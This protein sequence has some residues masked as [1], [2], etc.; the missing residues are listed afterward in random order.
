VN[1]LPCED[2]PDDWFTAS[3]EEAA[4]TT[5]GRCPARD[6]CLELALAG[7]EQHGVWGGLSAEDRAALTEDPEVLPGM[8]AVVEVELE[9]GVRAT[10]GEGCRCVQCEQ[11]NTRF[12]SEWRAKKRAKAQSQPEQADPQLMAFEG[13]AS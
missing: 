10:Y 3:T 6:A 1:V 8:P 7:N 11:A 13:I 5:C 12:V 4:K 2:A 9:H